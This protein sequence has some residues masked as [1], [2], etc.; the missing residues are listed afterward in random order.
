MSR[1]QAIPVGIAVA[2]LLVFGP[3]VGFDFL[4]YDDPINTFQNGYVTHWSLDN[5]LHFWK[6][7]HE[8]LYVPLTYNL[9]AMLAQAA[10]LWPEHPDFQIS[11]RPFHL[12]N[13]L[14]HLGGALLVHG[15]ARRLALGEIAAAIAALVFALHPV[16][17][18]P[19]AWVTGMKDVLAGCLSLLALWSYLAYAG[20]RRPGWYGLAL[21]AMG[22][23]LVAKPA[24]VVVPV[25]AAGIAVFFLQRGIGRVAVELVPWI[26]LALPVALVT[27]GAQAQGY[28]GFVPTLPQRL[29]V[30]S[31]TLVFYA[32][33][34]LAPLTLTAD[35]GRTPLVA[36]QQ[37]WLA[38]RGI[39]PWAVLLVLAWLWL[40]RRR[41]WPFW[42]MVLAIV[43][44]LPVSGLVPFTHQGV[45][46]VADRYLYLAMLGPALA[47]GRLAERFGGR[48]ALVATGI[49][50]AVLA[51]RSAVQL[52]HWKDSHAFYQ[53]TIAANPGSWFS[54]NNY[55]V[56]LQRK[57][58]RTEAVEAY[59]RAIGI[60]PFYARAYNNLGIVL[61]EMGRPGEAVAAFRKAME[62]APASEEA[63]MNL[64]GVYQDERRWAEAMAFYQKAMAARPDLA[65]AYAS[66]GV[67]AKETG[68]RDEAVSLYRKAIGFNP[69]FAE[70][71]NNLGVVLEEM[72]Q[73]P[74]AEAAYR[75]AIELKPGFVEAQN[76][77][78]HLHLVSGRYQEAVPF[79]EKAVTLAP[80]HPVPLDN[81]GQAL[82]GL[83]RIP[84][85][86]A[87]FRRAIEADPTFAP[88]REHLARLGAGP[89]RPSR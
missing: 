77:L 52:Q 48:S 39:L 41:P 12:A 53:H 23:A 64:G 38:G 32:G 80:R 34:I 54:L 88:A 3:S 27:S 60:N 45:S 29:A 68:R 28:E 26:A 4:S 14:L 81:L 59:R 33:K 71:H 11:P 25:L 66:M 78:G 13:L 35:Y 30:V 37:P 42:T 74:E 73:R 6:G 87:I 7:P 24:T 5:L 89:G 79:L 69:N 75:H 18:E 47:C 19:V 58:K 55:G 84:E 63:Y 36:L 31:D 72:G 43:A 1:R 2:V 20:N 62:I 61:K 46:T 9:W 51:A 16:Q 86:A 44:I 17:V 10:R 57:G 70:V 22:G 21:L 67:V 83:G 76:N 82:A 15:I 49:V 65:E 85:A 56:H 50:L 40:A 8:K